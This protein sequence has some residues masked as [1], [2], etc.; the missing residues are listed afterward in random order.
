MRFSLFFQDMVLA[1]DCLDGL[2]FSQPYTF[3]S[4]FRSDSNT[5]KDKID[6]VMSRLQINT[7]LEHVF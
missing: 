1:F 4:H 2:V 3:L 6:N 5:V 7:V